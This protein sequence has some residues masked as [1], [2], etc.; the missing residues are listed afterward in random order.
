MAFTIKNWGISLALI[1]ILGALASQAI[2]RTLQDALMYE[3]HEEW[4]TRYGRVYKDASEKEMRY[5]IFKKNVERIESFN[6]ASGKTY[7]LGVNKFADLTNEEFKTTRNRFK[8]HMC[9]AQAG[10][11][12]YE[13]VSAVPSSMDWRKKGAVTAIKDQGQ[14]GMYQLSNRS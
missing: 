8:G 5:Q 2:A 10:P 3:K 9:S 7:K 14:C 6:K 13:N 11:F 1:F 4:M 12:K